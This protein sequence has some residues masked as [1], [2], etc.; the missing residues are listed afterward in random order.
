MYSAESQSMHTKDYIPATTVPGLNLRSP[1]LA[2]THKVASPV[3]FD[4]NGGLQWRT[5]VLW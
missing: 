3:F 1:L 2:F 5:P 4:F